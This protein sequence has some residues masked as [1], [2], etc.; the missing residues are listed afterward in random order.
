MNNNQYVV[1]AVQSLN[2][3]QLSVI[4]CIV[5]HQAPLSMGFAR[6]EYWSDLPFPT[7]GDLPDLEI[8]SLSLHQQEDSLSLCQLGSTRYVGVIECQ[9][10]SGLD[11]CWFFLLMNVLRA[12]LSSSQDAHK[13][14]DI[15]SASKYI[16]K[17]KICSPK[18]GLCCINLVFLYFLAV[19]V[20]QLISLYLLSLKDKSPLL[21]NSFKVR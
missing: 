2:Y 14:T 11:L 21:H 16:T 6:Q 8:E 18:V 19:C 15:K 9:V 13:H 1:V 4:P 20:T 17:R 10:H 7:S 12:V 3:I 5:A